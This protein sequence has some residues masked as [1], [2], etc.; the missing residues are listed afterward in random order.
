MNQCH[1]SA[2]CLQAIQIHVKTK[3]INRFRTN[4]LLENLKTL[5]FI[6]NKVDLKMMALMWMNNSIS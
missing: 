1:G 2:K 4:N 3:Q 6:I 5:I